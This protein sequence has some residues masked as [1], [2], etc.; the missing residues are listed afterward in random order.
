MVIQ[1]ALAAAQK[2]RGVFVVAA[3]RPA[4][5][6]RWPEHTALHQLAH[7]VVVQRI[8]EAGQGVVLRTLAWH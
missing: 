3:A 5:R 7:A 1:A 4:G 2:V 8:T 6:L